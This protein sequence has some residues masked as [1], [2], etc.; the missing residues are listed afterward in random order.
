M[1]NNGPRNIPGHINVND[2][3]WHMITIVGQASGTLD[4][5]NGLNVFVDGRFAGH[6]EQGGDDFDP[7]GPVYLCGRADDQKDRHFGGRVRR[8]LSSKLLKV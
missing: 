8:R 6:G 7:T 3:K 5:Q 1:N 2:G 4:L